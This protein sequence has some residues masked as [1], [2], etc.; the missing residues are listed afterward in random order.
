MVCPACLDLRDLILNTDTTFS[1]KGNETSG[2]ASGP[3]IGKQHERREMF[4]ITLVVSLCVVPNALIGNRVREGLTQW[5]PSPDPSTNHSIACGIQHDGSARWF[6]HGGIFSE[7]KS[8]GSFLWIYGKRMS[9]SAHSW[10]SAD[11]LHILSWIWEEHPLVSRRTA[12]YPSKTDLDCCV[13]L[14]SFKT[15]RGYVRQ[16]WGQSPTFTSTSGTSI[17]KIVE[18]SSRLFSSNLPRSQVLAVTSCTGF[19]WSMQTVLKS[20]PKLR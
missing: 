10:L 20:P 13:A 9:F 15:S 5:V 16:D 6:F 19:T 17:S 2:F 18:T 12:L 14:Q 7:W 3:T 1:R 11:G 8:I 4:V